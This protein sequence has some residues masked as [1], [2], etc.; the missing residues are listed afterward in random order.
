M[1][2]IVKKILAALP[3]LV[4]IAAIIYGYP[5]V[6]AIKA[7]YLG[8]PAMAALFVGG[9]L[10]PGGLLIYWWQGIDRKAHTQD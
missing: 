8:I 9:F 6:Y 7:W 1:L 4:G 2:I 3:L 5:Y 10:V